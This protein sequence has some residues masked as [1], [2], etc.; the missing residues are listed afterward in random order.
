M[1]PNFYSKHSDVQKVDNAYV[2][3]KYSRWIKWETRGA[4]ILDVGCGDGFTTTELLLPR[5]PRNFEKLVGSDLSQKMVDFANATRQK[6]NITFLQQDIGADS[7]QR[8]LVAQFDHVFSFYC[9]HWVPHQ[10]NAFANIHE[11]L[12]PGGDVL[13]SFLGNHPLYDIYENLSKKIQWAPYFL[14]DFVSPYHHSKRPEE[15]VNIFMRQSGFIGCNC[16]VET[17]RF[18]FDTWDQVTKTLAAIDPTIKQ[19]GSEDQSKYIADFIEEARK[20]LWDKLVTSNNNNE[21]KIPIDY[22]LIVVYGRKSSKVEL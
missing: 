16:V 20:V 18:V 5:I 22:K 2:I 7:C 17:R 10:K 4:R 8:G 11:M 9:L 19:L 13:L 14:K 3:K 6:E 1:E 21:E 15:D 12:R